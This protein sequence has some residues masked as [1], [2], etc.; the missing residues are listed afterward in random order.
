MTRGIYA[1]IGPNGRR[2]IGQSAR[3]ENR[4]ASHKRMLRQGCH[5]APYLQNAWD[6]H[7]PEAFSFEIVFA[8]DIAVDLT[9]IEQN[10]IDI[11]RSTGLY[12]ASMIAGAPFNQRML[13][14]KREELLATLAPIKVS[15]QLYDQVKDLKWNDEWPQ[16][17]SNLFRSS[18]SVG[19][20][21]IIQENS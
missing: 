6:F 1:I 11:Y 18:L 20:R 19:H 3:I 21:L 15:Q 12:N 9:S 17:W 8:A 13:E 14:D 7:G 16:E 4:F 10:F 2:Y 5:H